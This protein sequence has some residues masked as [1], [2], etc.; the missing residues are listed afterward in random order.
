MGPAAAQMLDPDRCIRQD[1]ARLARERRRRARA[2][3]GSVP[4]NSDKRRLADNAI[5]AWS[6]ART[7]AVFSIIPESRDASFSSSS[8]MLSVDLICINMHGLLHRRQAAVPSV[9]QL[10][11]DR[12]RITRQRTTGLC[13][14]TRIIGG[15]AAAGLGTAFFEQRRCAQANA[16]FSMIE[17]QHDSRASRLVSR[18]DAIGELAQ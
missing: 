12:A 9:L 4:P 2:M 1:H 10:A 11:T 7:R 15:H 3:P 6:P 16:S 13:F 8:S 18:L 17:V 5:S 14:S